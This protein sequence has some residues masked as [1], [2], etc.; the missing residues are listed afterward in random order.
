MLGAEEEYMRS[1]FRRAAGISFLTLLLV[2][3]ATFAA[4]QGIVTGSLSGSV[5]DPQGA[6]VSN[7]AITATHVDTNRQFTAV[8]NEA[9]QFLMRQ[10]PSGHYKIA[11]SA[12]GFQNVEVKDVQVAVGQD[13]SLGTVKLQLGKTEETLTVEGTAPLVEAQSVQIQNTF[14]TKDT[15]NLPIG[16]T[17]DS[18]ALFVPGVATA[19]DV[20]FSN[21]NGA[22]FAVNGQRARSNNFQL[23]GQNNNDNSIGGPSIFFGNQDVIAELQ[24]ITN[25]TAEYGRNLGSVV[26]YITKAGTNQYHGTAFEF[27]QGNT[28]ASLANEEKSPVFGFC[29][30]AQNPATDGCT[31][32]VIPRFV[33]NQ[34]GGTFGGPIVRDK[35]WFF[36]SG[37]FVRQRTGASPLSSSPA[38]TP[39]PN[40]IQQLQAAFAGN[41]GV[42]ALAAVGPQAV[43]AGNPTFSN[44]Q[45]VTVSDGVTS[46]P[47]EFGE[48]TRNVPSV[49]NDYEATGRVDVQLTQK[50][51]F[52]GRYIFQQSVTTNFPFEGSQAGAGG[53][54]VNV[55]GRSQQIGLDYTHT[56]SNN[57]LN[58]AR[59]SYSRS[60]IGFE[61]GAFPD[62]VQANLSAC[63]TQ[64]FIDDPTFLG[65]GVNAGFPQGR[66]INVYQ[67]QDNASWLLGKHAIKFGGEYSKQRS[68]NVFLPF[69]NGFF[70]YD[71]FDSLLQNTPNFSAITVGSPRIPFKEHDLA[72]YL[73]DDWRIKSNLTINLGLRWE[74]FQQ[75]INNL[76]DSTVK[77]ETGANPIWDPTLPL[78]RTTVPSVSNDLNNFGPVVGFAWT[79]QIFKSVFGES[80]TVIRGGFRIAYDPA[81]YN[82]FL[83]VANTA[84]SVNSASFTDPVQSNNPG[85]PAA[86]PFAPDVQAALL[87]LVPVGDPGFAAQTH[88]GSDFHNPYSEQWNFGIQRLFGSRAAA[89]VRYVGNHTVGNFQNTNGN[90]ALQPLIDA[91]FGSLIPSGLTPCTDPSQPGSIAGYADC[92]RTNVN[93]Y[94]NTAYSIYH[95]LQTQF[96]IQNWHGVTAQASYTFSKTIDNA[97][98]I[99]STAAGGNTNSFA[100]NPFDLTRAERGLAGIDFPHVFGLLW[101]YE[102]PFAKNQ[103]GML[104]HVLGGWQL[105]STYRFSVGQPYTVVQRRQG[106]TLCDPTNWTGSSRDACRPIVSNPAASFTSVGQCTDPTLSDCGIVDFATGTPTTLDAVR[107]IVNDPTAAT[108]FGSPFLGVGRNTERGQPISTMNLGVFKNTKIGE[109]FNLQFQAEAFNL[110]NTQFRGVPNPRVTSVTTGQ[111]ASTAFNPNG[112]ATFAGNL[113]TDGI[114]RRRLQ[115]GLKLIF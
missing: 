86:G 79:P 105:N 43:A 98:E 67:V 65:F 107:W 85:L 84:P 47:V 60:R 27:W 80:Q 81:F 100:Q 93:T 16:N 112:G 20:S 26:N 12:T 41:P 44:L 29:T 77:R 76:H 70:E 3:A 53:D 9:G 23:D 108:F 101:I 82:M 6:L 24:V 49:F 73:Q 18:L 66:T 97:S 31:K 68:P 89:E 72:F 8:T 99:F 4:A 17:Y 19:G 37:N 22:E 14:T 5:Q 10:L 33:Q 71:T 92:A 25:Y 74:F 83:N 94:R 57:F 75:A 87:P 28:F 102:V 110:F 34:F 106:G 40:G 114:G 50:D 103:S 38:I 115:F 21:N 15:A 54:F 7:A 1:H 95:G 13:T 42:V 91:G 56:F 39:T 36:G 61:G 109:R 11:I 113:V 104:G 2:F 69:V 52:F 46:A 78:S 111:F 96:R 64:I 32:P 90:P 55:P 88:V 45:T 62:C 59:F 48:I 30:P 51:R 58:Q 63:P 35:V